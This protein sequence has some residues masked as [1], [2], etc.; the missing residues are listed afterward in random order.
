MSYPKSPES[1]VEAQEQK[2]ATPE[3]HPTDADSDRPQEFVTVEDRPEPVDKRRSRWPLIA[4]IA[5]VAGAA[6]FG[7]YSWQS[8]QNRPQQ[9]AAAAQPQAIPVK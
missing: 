2:S 5:I 8:S 4:T 6:G 7:L 9:P 1:V 3:L